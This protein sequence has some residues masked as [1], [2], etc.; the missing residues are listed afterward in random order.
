MDRFI[1]KMRESD[2]RLNQL[3][4]GT[5]SFTVHDV[6]TTKDIYRTVS[7]FLSY[8]SGMP[9]TPKITPNF[10]TEIYPYPINGKVY[11]QHFIINYEVDGNTIGLVSLGRFE[12]EG[13]RDEQDAVGAFSINCLQGLVH[14]EPGETWS[15]FM[16]RFVEM[17]K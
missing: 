10:K 4:D 9:G 16:K 13:G 14:S 15:H 6:S 5:P 11:H 12:K 3:F 7:T 2:S 8:F 17:L 1:Q